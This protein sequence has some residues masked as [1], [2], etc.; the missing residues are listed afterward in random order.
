[1]SA[2]KPA[3][4]PHHSASS[5]PSSRPAVLPLSFGA[6]EEQLAVVPHLRGP[7]GRIGELRG[8]DPGQ[9]SLELSIWNNAR[10]TWMPPRRRHPC[11]K[12]ASPTGNLR[13]VTTPLISSVDFCQI[14]HFA[15][16]PGAHES[17][18]LP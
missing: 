6:L 12:G 16:Y 2:R 8:Y 14:D 9:S 15:K 10:H 17:Q 18:R 3:A 7:C 1:M 11:R 5:R 4:T 13:M